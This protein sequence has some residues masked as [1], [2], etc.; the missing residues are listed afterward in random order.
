MFKAMY[1]AVTKPDTPKA[2]FISYEMPE[3]TKDKIDD[4]PEQW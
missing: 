4:C 2:R 3:I 1:E